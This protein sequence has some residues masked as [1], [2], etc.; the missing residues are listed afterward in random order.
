MYLIKYNLSLSV[1][2]L[3]LKRLVRKDEL[4]ERN[5]GENTSSFSA[6]HVPDNPR[7]PLLAYKLLASSQSILAPT[8]GP[9]LANFG[10]SAWPGSYILQRG[11]PFI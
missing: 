5:D 7:L 3:L 6:F 8:Q 11:D 9:K 1:S 2:V 4:L 10:A